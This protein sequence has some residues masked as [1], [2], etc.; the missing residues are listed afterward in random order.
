MRRTCPY[1]R[2]FAALLF[3]V[4]AAGCREKTASPPPSAPDEASAKSA[5]E[6]KRPPF[7]NMATAAWGSSVMEDMAARANKD[8][9]RSKQLDV[10]LQAL[11]SL[12][13]GAGDLL[14]SSAASV[15]A[16]AESDGDRAL[17][18]ALAAVGLVLEPSSEGYKERLTDAHGIAAFAGTL[19]GGTAVAQAAR[20]FI[21]ISA[22]RVFEGEKLVDVMSTTSRIDPDSALL[23]ALARYTLGQR[24]DKVIEQ[25]R[26][27]LDDKPESARARALLARTYLDLGLPSDAL[28]VLDEGKAALG[29]KLS[30]PPLVALRGRAQLAAGD[31][32]AGTSTLEGV[33]PSLSATERGEA[34]Y[35]LA[36][37]LVSQGNVPAAATLTTQ[38]SSQQGFSV[39]AAL[40]GALLDD[41]RGDTA[42]AKEKVLKVCMARGLYFT[43]ALECLWSTTEVCARSG[44][45]ACVAQWGKK[46]VGSDDDFARLEH[47]RATLAASGTV[48]GDDTIAADAPSEDPAGEREVTSDGAASDNAAR[49]DA[50]LS[51]DV[52]QHLTEAHLLSPFD[53]ALAKRLALDV[54]GGGEAAARLVRGARRALAFD[55]KKTAEATL[56]RLAKEQPTCRVCRALL[57]R[58]PTDADEAGVRAAA[59]LSGKGPALA[60][61]DLMGLIDV[62]G[63]SSSDVAKAALDQLA[64]DPR[65]SVKDAVRT[66][67][68][69]QQNPE[70]RAARKAEQA[71]KPP[72]PGSAPVPGS[73]EHG[74]HR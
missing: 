10:S 7:P 46:A 13:A 50:A 27:A 70:A 20:A 25:A 22:G 15:F 32:E 40:L 51:P 63:G 18:A 53:E 2:A 24:N 23:L 8:G 37:A 54:A 1:P 66:A 31:I 69:D 34:Q 6:K 36:R 19:E 58:V 61:R 42:K 3:V 9:A 35:W 59:A 4:A 41:A 56:T 55:A 11:H 71:E 28:R 60:E 64:S 12:D 43:V 65:P 14:T 16:N 49:D 26:R 62:L 68:K 44:D 5:G 48:S 67:K 57:A 73:T 38:L 21:A 33:M 30:A 52:R 29:D 39:E 45:A 74:E 72:T 47:A 17:G